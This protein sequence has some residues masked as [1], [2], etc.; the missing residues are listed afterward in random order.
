MK[1]IFYHN[2]LGLLQLTWEMLSKQRAMGP[3]YSCPKRARDLMR[4][5]L[6]IAVAHAQK[7][8]CSQLALVSAVIWGDFVTPFKRQQVIHPE[9]LSLHN[10]NKLQT[11]QLVLQITYNR[12]VSKGKHIILPLQWKHMGSDLEKWHKAIYDLKTISIQKNMLST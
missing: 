7:H 3:M 11:T 9:S 4:A 12:A 1:C 10:S 8:K 5:E 6:I 2:N